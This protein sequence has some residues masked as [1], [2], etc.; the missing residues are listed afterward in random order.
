MSV[1]RR[2]EAQ[3]KANRSGSLSLTLVALVTRILI[4]DDEDEEQGYVT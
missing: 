1:R 4:V 2:R 3:H